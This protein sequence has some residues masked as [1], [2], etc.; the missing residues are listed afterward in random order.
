MAD[1]SG[2]VVGIL[3][4]CVVGTMALCVCSSLMFR[5]LVYSGAQ[6]FVTNYTRFKTKPRA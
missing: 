3:F 1:N 5:S 4:V 2:A 6:D